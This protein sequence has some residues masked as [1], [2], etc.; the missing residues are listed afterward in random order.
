MS[1]FTKAE[2]SAFVTTDGDYGTGVITFDASDLSTTEWEEL[3]SMHESDRF[4]FVAFI[5]EERFI[6]SR[7]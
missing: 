6:E 4:D 7:D 2:N 5:L 1:S 3:I